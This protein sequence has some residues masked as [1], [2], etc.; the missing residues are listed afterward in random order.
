VA[1]KILLVS[2]TANNAF[3]HILSLLRFLLKC[4]KPRVTLCA[5]GGLELLGVMTVFELE[6]SLTFLRN[7]G[8][9]GLAF[10]LAADHLTK[11]CDVTYQHNHAGRSRFVL[12]AL[13][14]EQ[15]TFAI[16]VCQLG[17]LAAKIACE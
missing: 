9:V 13:G 12:F 4:D 6:L 7:L 16:V 15:N 14:E 1:L 5:G 11:K 3:L 2:L 10:E 8:D 17:F